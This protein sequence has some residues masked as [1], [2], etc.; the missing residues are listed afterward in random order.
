[1]GYANEDDSGYAGTYNPETKTATLQM[2][3]YC[4][5]GVFPI[6]QESFT[7]P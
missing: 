3:Y 5:D 6:Q 4:D 2:R 1:M 7:M